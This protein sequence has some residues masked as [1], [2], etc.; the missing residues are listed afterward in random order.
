MKKKMLAIAFM[1]VMMICSLGK[2][3]VAAAEVTALTFGKSYSGTITQ[4]LQKD[5]YKITVPSAGTMRFS[6]YSGN[7]KWLTLGLYKEPE[8]LQKNRIVY[9]TEFARNDATE[10]LDGTLNI[11]V[12]KGTYYLCADIRGRK[13]LG[14]YLVS[15]TYSKADET[16][17]EGDYGTNNTI[18]KADA[19]TC[20][21]NY[22]GFIADNDRYDWYK[23]TVGKTE[24]VRI[25][26]YAQSS[27]MLLYLHDAAGKQLWYDSTQSKTV[28]NGGNRVI[29]SISGNK[30]YNKELAAGTYY[31]K[32]QNA[33]HTG[34][35]GLS[36][37]HEHVFSNVLIPATPSAN[38]AYQQKCICGYVGASNPIYAPSNI[39]L[40]KTSYTY[41]GKTKKPTVTVKD[42]MGNKISSSDYSVSYAKGCKKVGTYKVTI[43]FKGTEYTGKTTKTF[44]IKPKGTSISK[45]TKGKKRFTVKWKKQTKETTGYEVQYSLNKNFKNAVTENIK[46]NKT[47]SATYKKL[48]AKKTYYVR[49]R[50]YKK[51][52]GQ[53]ICSS[54]SKAKSIKTK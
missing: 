52:S 33:S 50:T 12:A 2:M 8:A 47:T 4:E 36:V 41:D 20:G 6:A 48:Q 44:T 16:I 21:T 42:S 30:T 54:W 15:V 22:F 26:L 31:I 27:Q 11:A 13:V 17:P 38:G 3:D 53:N 28:D 45:L 49:V 10:R 23:F 24:K 18:D 14:E 51:V 7:L 43:T 35:Y 5:W 19:I 37:M 39:K 1:A 46:K 40:S 9:E 29:D 32:V 34:V 25:K